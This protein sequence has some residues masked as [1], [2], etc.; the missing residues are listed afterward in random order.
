VIRRAGARDN[1]QVA[2]IWNHEALHTTATTD[3]EPRTAAA[4][5]AWLAAHTIDYPVLVA[6][7]ADEVLAFGGLAP[8]RPKPSYRHTVEDSVYVKDGYRGKG[9]GA[10]LLA[11]LVAR[12][13]ARGHHSVLARITSE[14]A[15]SLR[16]HERLGF[17]RAGYERQA[18]FKLGRWLDVVTLQRLL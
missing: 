7:E 5:A 15:A 17:Q 11:A 6:V 1:A 14:N 4:Q 10:E 13:A 16:L 2:A 9:L 18:A 3:T 8:Y 12:A